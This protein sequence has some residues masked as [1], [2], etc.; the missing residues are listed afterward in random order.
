MR[1]LRVSLGVVSLLGLSG[2]S[3]AG[4]PPAPPP[5]MSGAAPGGLP[6]A[7]AQPPGPRAGQA[8]PAFTL[9]AVD[10]GQARALDSFTKAKGKK[11]AVVVFLSCKCPYVVQARAPLGELVK[12]YGDKI[13]FVGVNANQNEKTDEIKADAASS[14]PFPMLRDEGSKV[15]DLYGAQRTPEVFL[16]DPSGVI[17]YHGGVADLG[18]AL[19][20]LVAGSPVAKAESK[21]FG[22]TIKRK[23]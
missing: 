22:C 18:A 3:F 5:G 13:S 4:E 16:V 10:S 23:P 15:A 6:V 17:R 21:A 19:G 7:P 2:L 8:A 20:Q 12:Q 1:A 11:G 9:N 14:F